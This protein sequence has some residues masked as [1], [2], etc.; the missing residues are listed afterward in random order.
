M[1]QEKE[2]KTE[3]F[4]EISLIVITISLG[5]LFYMMTGY[6]MVVLNLF[7]LPVVLAGFFLGRYRAGV[8]AVLC[9][10]TAAIITAVDLMGFAAFTSPLIIGLAIGVWAAVLGL[11]S[12][13]VGT[14]SDERGQTIVELHEAYVGVVEVLSRYLQ[15]ANPRLKARSDR[16]AELSQRVAV[17]MKLS[18]KEAD[19]I[20]VAALLH[21]MENI[22][23]TARVIRKAMGSIE[24]E[25]SETQQAT[26]HGTD[27][28][29]S[30]GAV[31]TGAMPLLVN[32]AESG[33][34]AMSAEDAP[35]AAHLPVGAK[36]I[37]TVRA[38]E[39]VREGTLGQPA[40]SP[41]AAFEELRRDS[42]ANHDPS[43]VGVLERIVVGLDRRSTASANK[44]PE[45][46]LV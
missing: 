23:I 9:V 11:T 38:Y 27:L 1:S 18:P 32:Q 42:N 7:Y 40:P 46:E 20:R 4:I 36:I 5:C 34:A 8:L 24:E 43:I 26:F 19:D 2:Q 33:H 16:V 37:R 3:R 28:V 13:L 12:I 35:N 14:L 31:L 6:K 30:L 25:P 39:Q 15:S 45:L 41:Q 44:T 29:H 10:T 21:D 17:E 22:E